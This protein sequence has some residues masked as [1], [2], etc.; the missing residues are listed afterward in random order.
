MLDETSTSVP[1]LGRDCLFED[2]TCSRSAGSAPHT[3]EPSPQAL[4]QYGYKGCTRRTY[5]IRLSSAP[6]QTCRFLEDGY[7]SLQDCTPNE[8]L[9]ALMNLRVW[10]EERA[11]KHRLNGR[12]N[13]FLALDMA[14]TFSGLEALGLDPRLLRVFRRKSRAFTE[15]AWSRAAQHAGDTGPSDV[16]H[17]HAAYQAGQENGV[18]L[19]LVAHFAAAATAAGTPI[20]ADAGEVTT[21]ET[22]L[23]RQLWKTSPPGFPLSSPLQAPWI[24]VSQPLDWAGTVYFGYKDGVTRPQFSAAGLQDPFTPSEKHA[25]G[26]VLLGHKRNQHDNPYGHLDL[27]PAAISPDGL[28]WQAVLDKGAEELNFFKN[29]SFAVFRKMQQKEDVFDAWVQQQAIKLCPK[30]ADLDMWETWVKAK[31]MGR[32]PRVDPNKYP[33][34]LPAG[35]RLTPEMR[36]EHLLD[37]RPL[38]FQPLPLNMG[39]EG[40]FRYPPGP[41]VDDP[42]GLGCPYASHIRRMNPKDDPVVPFTARPLLRRGMTYEEGRNDEAGTPPSEVGLSGLFIC[43]DIEAQ[44]EHLVGRWANHRVMGVV[45]GSNG[46]DPIIGQH[47]EDGLHLSIENMAPFPRQQL[48]ELTEAFVLTRGCVYAWFPSKKTLAD[49][50]RFL[51]NP[52][53]LTP[54][55]GERLV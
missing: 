42:L 44:F 12:T 27:P 35:T 11:E 36:P 5:F 26:E 47:Q 17:W 43:A 38:V 10:V 15:G 25:W 33:H 31:V 41:A 30:P 4:V 50:P 19:I 39:R 18:D 13:A 52:Q 28:R 16:K 22:E 2:K 45:D 1:G 8:L 34:A 14:W 29:S 48:G 9:A 23:C 6:A 20:T 40:G 21:F 32:M 54:A 46:R 37:K 7:V 3:L 55:G 24:E 49:L 51:R 53:N